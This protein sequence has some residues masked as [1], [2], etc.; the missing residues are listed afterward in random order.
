MKNLKQF[1]AFLIVGLSLNSCDLNDDCSDYACFTPP[2]PIFF[3]LYSESDQDL[4]AS[5][6]FELSSLKILDV[7]KDQFIKR[8]TL[9]VS[10][11]YYLMGESIGW[12]DGLNDYQFTYGD[13]EL[14]TFSIEANEISEDCCAYTEY[15]DISLSG[16]DFEELSNINTGLVYRVTVSF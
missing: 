4:I 11:E 7:S 2:Q 6:T 1:V 12:Q 15:G 5:D 16:S 8:D 9:S 13:K 10:G 14:F 3:Q